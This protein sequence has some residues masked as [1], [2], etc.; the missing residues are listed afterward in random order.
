M[1]RSA[2]TF[3]VVGRHM[4][5]LSKMHQAKNPQPTPTTKTNNTETIANNQMKNNTWKRKRKPKERHDNHTRN[6][7]LGAHTQTQ[8]PMPTRI[9]MSMA[10]VIMQDLSESQRK[11]SMLVNRLSET[12]SA[13]IGSHNVTLLY[14]PSVFVWGLGFVFGCALLALMLT[15]GFWRR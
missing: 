10:M 11:N 2:W 6:Q 8:N 9:W 7:K 15:C 12:R 14:L 5:N 4:Q 1:S 13:A 3:R